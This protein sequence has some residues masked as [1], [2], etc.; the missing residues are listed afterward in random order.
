MP[1]LCGNGQLGWNASAAFNFRAG[2][3]PFACFRLIDL[4]AAEI[5]LFGSVKPKFKL[6]KALVHADIRREQ[7]FALY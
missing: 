7:R 4:L 5:N 3:G 6:E 2:N 1:A